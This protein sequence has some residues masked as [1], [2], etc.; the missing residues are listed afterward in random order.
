MPSYHH[1]ILG[2][3][4]ATGTL[5]SKLIPSGESIAVIE[6]DKIG[7]S[8]VNYGCTPTKSLV[9]SAKAIHMARRGTDFGFQTGSIKVDF[10]KV[11]ARMNSIRNGSSDGLTQWMETTPNVE[12]IRGWG[13]LVGPNSLL[14]NDQILQGERIY[15]NTGTHPFLPPISG[16]E[17]IP[18]LDSAG[19][20]DLKTLPEHLL[21]MG[22]GYIGV[23]F[24]QVFRRFGSEVT[25]I[26][27]GEQLMPREDKDVADTIQ[28][29]LEEEGIRILTNAQV[30]EVAQEGPKILL[31]FE[32]EGIDKRLFGSHLLVATGR[33][34]NSDQLGLD[35]AGIL[36]DKRGYIQVDD[37]CQTNVSGVFALGDVNG[38]RSL[39]AHLRQ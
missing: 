22:G 20:L 2:T 31:D 18:W 6:G 27:R 36:T 4:Q 34:P 26:Q 13:K 3:G 23:E 28:S 15:I 32:S 10:F 11:Y 35:S 1:I 14:V 30:K 8:C 16:I 7:G 9:A 29:F 17:T 39:Y 33:R 25:I 37:Y 19:L 38:K 24:A 5:L 21:I 12:L